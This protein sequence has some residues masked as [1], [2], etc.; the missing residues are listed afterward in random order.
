M[1][2]DREREVLQ[3]IA[4]GHTS[5]EIAQT[6]GLKVKTVQNYRTT[7]MDKLQEQTTAGLVRYAIRVGLVQT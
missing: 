5:K 3:L 7:I 2:T 4:E 6:L 1:L